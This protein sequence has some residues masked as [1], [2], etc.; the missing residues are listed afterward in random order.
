MDKVREYERLAKRE[1]PIYTRFRP[2]P[3]GEVDCMINK[4]KKEYRR[5]IFIAALILRDRDHAHIE[6]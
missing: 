3:N 6:K 1:I 5:K 2:G 4:T